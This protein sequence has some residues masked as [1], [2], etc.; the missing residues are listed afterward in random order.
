[1]SEPKAPAWPVRL[2]HSILGL[3]AVTTNQGAVCLSVG[4]ALAYIG[5]L[6]GRSTLELPLLLFLGMACT[7]WPVRA[8]D[9]PERI[10]ERKFRKWD[11]WVKDKKLSAG[12]CVRWK[13]QFRD[14]YFS[15]ITRTPP[16]PDPTGLLPFRE[17]DD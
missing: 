17:D 5:L 14:W 9:S 12:E 11:R 13:R 8:F 3:F 16:R 4:G 10:L 2:V 1:M 7:L 15:E 6:F